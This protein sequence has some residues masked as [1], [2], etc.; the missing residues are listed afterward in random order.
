MDARIEIDMSELGRS[1]ANLITAGIRLR[2]D[3]AA[4]P[5]AGWTDA[6]VVVLSWWA[7]AAARVLRERG[8]VVE[9]RFM[10]GPFLVSVQGAEEGRWRLELVEAGPRRRVRMNCCVNSASL[11]ESLVAACERTLAGCS[12]RGWSTDTKTLE[13]ALARLRHEQGRTTN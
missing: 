11:I 5:H 4:F 8:Q 2:V 7:D 13:Q 3:D 10:E 1:A 9:V 12:D 6:V